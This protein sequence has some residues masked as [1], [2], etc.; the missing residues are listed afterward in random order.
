MGIMMND[1]RVNHDNSEIMSYDETGI[2]IVVRETYLS[3]Y[4]NYR[5]LGHWHE[6]VE[7]IQV[8]DGQMSYHVNG[9][10]VRLKAGDCLIVN[11]GRFHYNYSDLHRE[12]HFR[13]MILHPALLTSNKMLVKKYIT[14]VTGIDKKDYHVFSKD[15][16][17]TGLLDE[18]YRLKCNPSSFYEFDMIRVFQDLW[19]I[20]YRVWSTELT[21]TDKISDSAQLAS[22]QAMVSYIYQNYASTL[23]LD[24]IAAAG[25]MCRSQCC[26]IFKK[27]VGQSP[28]DFANSY[29]L[30]ISR[31]FLE[32]T[33]IHVTD[34]CMACGF[35]H[36][37]YF[38]KQFRRKY[39]CTPREYRKQKGCAEM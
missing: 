9:K 16:E 7:L 22:Q 6:D 34:I 14:A 19:K 32:E 26:L 17:V 31:R 24:E 3:T 15:Q 35:N 11:S 25:N 27:Y 10:N 37:S 33:S 18:M 29:R 36:L 38:T 13:C 1:I 23:T 39:G 12:C 20:L 4:P 21:T 2:P 5:V 8:L 30:E 28:M